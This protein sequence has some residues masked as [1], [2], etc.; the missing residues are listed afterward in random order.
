MSDFKPN[1]PSKATSAAIIGMGGRFPGAKTLDAFWRNLR[2]GLESVTTF[3]Q[4]ELLAA[5]AA[6]SQL[7]N[8]AY[9][10]ARS[11]LDGVELFDAGFFDFSPREAEI[12]DPQQRLFLEVCWEALESAG[13]DPAQYSGSIGVYAG[14]G[15]N[16]YFLNHLLGH[17]EV[18]D[19]VGGYQ[20]ML[21]SNND[22]LSTRIA[23]KLNLKGP[24]M[25]VQTACSTSL[26]ALHLAVQSLLN[27]ECDMALAGGVRIALPQES[28][29]LY[30]EGGVLSPD[31]HCRAFDA[32][33][34]GTVD[35]NGAGVVLLKRLE[36]AE[37][38]G[39]SILA[40]VRGT[41]INN[42]GAQKVGYT[43][44]SIDGQA[45]VIAMAQALSLVAPESI[46]Y[47]EAHGT[48]TKLG[49]PIELAA[50]QQ[51]FGP[52]AGKGFCAIG[53]VKTNIGHLDAAA[54][55][56]GLI[57]TVLALQHRQVPPSL[58]F[59]N[60]NPAFDF[61][62]SP[63]FVSAAL[64][65]WPEGPLPR[66]AGV[67]SFGIGGT[68]AHVVLEE[69][70][71]PARSGLSRPWQLLI[72]SARSLPA[73]EQAGQNLVQHLNESPDLNLADVAYTLQVGRKAFENRRL[74]VCRD[75]QDALQT[76]ESL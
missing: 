46:R 25:T 75:R 63:F 26:V 67:S 5:G 49:D 3:S 35:G 29:Y 42:D 28:G 58:H 71:P 13:Y 37:K 65:S 30:E 70:P 24:S 22:F 17:P 21:G 19:S 34:Q 16:T 56:A 47:L 12:L 23:Y 14:A 38:D 39:D 43:A 73:L 55:V 54:G 31:G 50:L 69:A 44:P 57:K 27:G 20:V 59:E 62:S 4:E 64:R 6:P 52:D 45:E 48:A 8:P 74:L 68:N 41:A 9:V 76:L 40:V 1:D 66:R 53:S 10:P 72:L 32:S 11:I 15:A 18:L 36:E 2:Q 60:P 61:E 7:A 33:A 51:A